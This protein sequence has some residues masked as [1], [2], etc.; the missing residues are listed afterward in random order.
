VDPGA[1]RVLDLVAQ[2]T[3]VTLVALGLLR[4]AS[5]HS[6]AA[7]HAVALSALF[8]ILSSPAIAGGVE[9][10]GGPAAAGA[11]I[12][13]SNGSLHGGTAMIAVVWLAGVLFQL[14][15]LWV[16]CR[17]VA[18]LRRS[19]RRIDLSGR[20]ALLEEVR[21]ALDQPVLPEIAASSLV[22]GPVVLGPLRPLVLLPEAMATTLD[23]GEL[24]DVLLHEC[25]H[26]V[27]RH[28]W[29]C[30]AQRLAVVLFW[31]HPLVHRL[32]GEL[33]RAREELCDNFVLRHSGAP[34][35]A[36]TLLTVACS[37]PPVESAPAGSLLNGGAQRQRPA[38]RVEAS[39]LESRVVS[40]LDCRRE[41]RT[42]WDRWK[43]VVL[44]SIFLTVASSV[45]AMRVS[46]AA[47]RPPLRASLAAPA[48]KS[49]AV[50]G[51]VRSR[52]QVQR[53]SPEP[54]R[55]RHPGVSR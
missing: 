53:S 35:Y 45:S 20:R 6:A 11:V 52:A 41:T 37:A 18:A 8:C 17:R 49:G 50:E 21:I 32:C 47:A 14:F 55:A 28:H 12:S 33:D 13:A 15:R 54:L 19:A 30:W 31:P 9:R 44:A 27:Q 42:R 25:A 16:G 39:S 4:L 43:Q 2:V 5:R 26:L 40:L 10:V 1:L 46:H 3:A 22:R 36:R 38:R 23:D 51:S 29:L 48:A 7:R 24:R 34:H